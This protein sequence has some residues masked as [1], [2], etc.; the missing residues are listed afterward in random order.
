MSNC[1]I[2]KKTQ[3]QIQLYLKIL[4]LNIINFKTIMHYSNNFTLIKIILC[5]LFVNSFSKVNAQFK[6]HGNIVDSTNAPVSYCAL[7]L[8][9][10]TDSS[11]VKGTITD[12]SGQYAFENVPSGKYFIKVS[13]IEFKEGYYNSFTFDS[14]SNYNVKAIIVKSNY[15][16]LNEVSVVA[17]KKPIEIK[18][19]MMIMNVENSSL[20]AGNT[21]YDLIKRIPGVFIDNQNNIIL[22]G[23][24][25]VKVMI[26][27]QIQ[28]VSNDQLI[29]IL[30]GMNAELVSKIEI[31]KN[32]P[33]K[34]DSEGSGG[35]INIVSKKVKIMGLSGSVNSNIN[36]GTFYR[37]SIDCSINYKLKKLAIFSNFGYGNRIFNTD[38]QFNQDVNILDSLTYLRQKG[39]V[40]TT[41]QLYHYSLGTDYYLN[42][43][44]TIGFLISGGLTSAPS[45]NTSRNNITGHNTYPYNYTTSS[46]QLTDNFS[47]PNYNINAEHKFDTLGTVLN[48]AADYSDF[49]EVKNKLNENFFFTQNDLIAQPE[50]TFKSNTISRFQLFTQKL[51]F[52]KKI[53]G[54]ITLES[55]V[56]ATTVQNKNNYLFER[57]NVTTDDFEKDS[58][59]SNNFSYNENIYAGYVNFKKE[60]KI[61]TVQLG[62]R[63]ENTIVSAKDEALFNLARNYFNFFPNLSIDY[64]KS[65]KHTLQL[66]LS[67]RI[68]RPSYNDLNPYISYDDYFSASKGNPLLLPTINYNVSLAYVYKQTIY[69]TIG[70]SVN[71]NHIVNMDLK[72]DSTNLVTNTMTNIKSYAVIY[73]NLYYQ[74]ELRSWWNTSISGDIYTQAFK[75]NVNNTSFNRTNIAY[76]AIVNNDFILFKKYK[77]MVNGY[78][79]S[80]TIY[81]TTKSSN[82][83]W[84]DLGL[85]KSYLNDKLTFN[86]TFSDIFHTNNYSTVIQFQNQNNFYKGV[87]DT[88]RISFSVIYKF[89]KLKIDTR[90]VQSNDSEKARLDSQMKK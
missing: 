22:S 51:D 35:L 43:N 71:N 77:L 5:L 73:Y 72:L 19:G 59:I 52:T 15:I 54:G 38:Y 16:K 47:N 87:R 20:A 8:V 14:L 56:K 55:G 31:I 30:M 32:P 18:D 33:V 34:Y 80:Q 62:S 57:K 61:A 65:D 40:K 25:S 3:Q 89:G 9:K 6:I 45:S 68:D 79:F 7:A 78:Y 83:W 70:Y 23:K 2:V 82:F 39:S 69:N 63:F 66:S 42:K 50:K 76:Q 75:G 41:Q 53:R 36:K 88:R 10:S 49:K 85:K 26:N 60:F 17:I 12:E 48:F 90:Q 4:L 1:I 84:V 74:K 29:S 28:R 44:N 27:G 58:S 13:S 64:H 81:S 37:G 86:L 21:V 24:G 46:L 67:K 11:I